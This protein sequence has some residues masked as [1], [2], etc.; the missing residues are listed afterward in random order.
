M[1][2]VL[3]LL[4]LWVFYAFGDA[5][6]FVYHRFGDDRY[7]ST[8]IST[9]KLKEQFDYFKENGYEVIPLSR[10]VDALEKGEEILD[11]WV[12]LTIDDN[13]HSFY[14]NGLP[15]FK[16]YGYPFSLFVYV[17]AAQKKYGDYSSWDELREI[18][19]FGSVE[20]HSYGHAHMSRFSKEE[21][22]EDFKKG[23]ELF[24]KEMGFKPKYFTH[25]YGEFNEELIEVAKSFGFSALINQNMGAVSSSSNPYDLDRTALGENS[26]LKEFLNYKYLNAKWIEP[27]IYPEDG[28][29]KEVKAVLSSEVKKAGLYVTGNGWRELEVKDGKVSKDLNLKLNHER[30]RLILSVGNSISTKILTKD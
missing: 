26:N 1:L 28:I 23:L 5:H 2:R 30:V 15:I 12:V 14:K 19:K 18:A 7:P 29:L 16:E 3:F 8:N 25:P 13:Y 24:E 10:L 27:S 9:Q 17:K 11:N 22:E 6:I 20:F 21:L 4:A